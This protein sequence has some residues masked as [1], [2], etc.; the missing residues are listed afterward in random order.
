MSTPLDSDTLDII[1]ATAPI[2]EEHAE[3]LTT[4]FYARM[5]EHNPEVRLFFNPAHQKQGQQQRALAGAIVA[6]AKNIHRLELLGSAVELIAHKH[7]SLG[8]RPEHY[9]VVGHHLIAALAEL[10]GPQATPEILQ[11]WTTAY[12][13][14]AQIMI[15]RETELYLTHDTHHGW[16]G[17]RE[18]KVVQRLQESEEI[19]SFYLEPLDGK[20][21]AP[22]SPGQYLTVRG[23]SPETGSTMRQYS[24]SCAPNAESYRISVKRED[25]AAHPGHISNWLHSTVKQGDL[26][27]LGP[28]CGEFVLDTTS[29]HPIVLLA[30]GVGITP[31]LAMMHAMEEDAHRQVYLVQAVRHGDVHAFS[32]ELEK[33]AAHHTHLHVHTCYEHPTTQDRARARFD[34]EGR[35][36]KELLE[37]VL[38][39]GPKEVYFCGPLP[40]MKAIHAMLNQLKIEPE[41][42]HHESFGPF[43]PLS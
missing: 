33:L 25:D 10:L 32:D 40:F 37:N 28:P 22:H 1:S 34:S 36:S 14:L 19:T 24:I 5:F 42:I 30:G 38:P 9:P 23:P 16:Q 29:P 41:H 13:L 6:Y 18:F 2:L 12:N 7:A 17:F 31:L 4:L 26:I 3:A 39:E 21:L 43:E 15:G 8:V 11:A 20:P 35:I 27:E